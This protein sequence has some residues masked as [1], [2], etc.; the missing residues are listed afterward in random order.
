MKKFL[1]LG[2]VLF[3][4]SAVFAVALS[5]NKMSYSEAVKYCDQRG[6]HVATENELRNWGGDDNNCYWVFGGSKA[7]RAQ[8]GSDKGCHHDKWGSIHW[9]DAYVYCQ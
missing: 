1:V 9:F 7:I 5:S 4:F 8:S 3:S 6:L 2:L